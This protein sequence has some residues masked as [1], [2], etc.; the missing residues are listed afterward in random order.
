VRHRVYTYTTVLSIGTYVN[1]GPNGERKQ[2]LIEPLAVVKQKLN[3]A[4]IPVARQKLDNSH[5]RSPKVTVDTQKDGSLVIL[6]TKARKSEADRVKMLQQSI[7]NQLIGSETQTLKPIQENN[8]LH[9]E[10][11]R[12]ELSYAQSNAVKTSQLQPEQQKIQSLT[13]QLAAMAAAYKKQHLD[14]EDQV[15]STKRQLAALNDA[16]T[17]MEGKEK[18]IGQS[19]G[20]VR[21]QLKE[22]QSLVNQLQK[23]RLQATDQAKTSTDAMT[24]LMVG[25]QVDQAQQRIDSLTVKLKVGLPQKRDD[26]VKALA[27]NARAQQ[28]AKAKWVSLKAQIKKLESDYSRKRENQ[29]SQIA[30]AKTAYQKAQVDY[31]QNIAAKKRDIQSMQAIADQVIPTKALFTAMQSDKPAGPGSL[32]I[33]ILACILGLMLA[34]F[35]AFVSEFIKQANRH[36]ANR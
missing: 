11:A 28:N 23:S 10:E 8:R 27:D 29:Q 21:E 14:L 19:E 24:L 33:L 36:V 12:Q 7:V 32:L 3:Q 31:Q 35:S 22:Q 18:R 15:A 4:F 30:A 34:I 26:T 5:K 16:R 6:K 20:L 25:T 2:E 13:R 1:K 17:L 9:L